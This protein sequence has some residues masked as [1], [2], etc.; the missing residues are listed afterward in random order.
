MMQHELMEP[1][2]PHSCR[3]NDN[4][5]TSCWLCDGGLACCKACG[6]AE[7]ELDDQ[8]ECLG[9]RKRG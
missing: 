3:R 7:A 6:M 4:V 2:D 1:N 8:P 5:P 9:V